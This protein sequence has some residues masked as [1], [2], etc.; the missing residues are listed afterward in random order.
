MEEAEEKK[1]GGQE[2][3]E[4]E[5]EGYPGLRGG[6]IISWEVETWGVYGF[7]EAEERPSI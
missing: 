5:Y 2:D 7:T 6:T 3:G 1:E 4:G